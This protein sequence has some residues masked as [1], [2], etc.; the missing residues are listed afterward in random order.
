VTP[1]LGELLTTLRDS[2]LPSGS[3][4]TRFKSQRALDQLW[5]SNP[6]VDVLLFE[7]LDE[8]APPEY[9]SHFAN[10]IRNFGKILD[11]ARK[12]SLSATIREALASPHY[13]IDAKSTLANALI[14]FHDSDDNLRSVAHLIPTAPDD[15]TSAS[16]LVALTLS[17]SQSGLQ[18]LQ[19]F[20][21]RH[22]SAPDTRPLS[23]RVTLPPLVRVPDPAINDSLGKIITHTGNP[24]LLEFT[25]RQLF[26][27]PPGPDTLPIVTL[28]LNRSHELSPESDPLFKALASRGLDRWSRDQDLSP[29]L[30][31]SLQELKSTLT[32]ESP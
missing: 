7:A 16:L 23:L 32:P 2:Y 18:S 1:E 21:T 31:S 24:K 17:K 8:N 26:I 3:K 19:T 11:S 15:Q 29:D 20:T 28:A 13:Q 27:R 9:R 10:R 22:S 6:P 25:F 30:N 4:G 14:A 12:D 5:T